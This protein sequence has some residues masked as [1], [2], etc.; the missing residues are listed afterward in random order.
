MHE[1][2]CTIRCQPGLYYQ[3]QSK[4]DGISAS[5]IVVYDSRA[6]LLVWNN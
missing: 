1:Y 6:S 3:S 2:I 5:D 4:A